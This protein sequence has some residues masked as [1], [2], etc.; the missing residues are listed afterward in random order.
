MSFI[1]D[2][3]RLGVA[4]TL[5]AVEVLIALFVRDGL[6]RPYGGD[7]LVV[8]L[9]HFTW[10]GVFRTAPR[11]VAM[12]CFAFACSVEAAQALGLAQHLGVAQHWAGRLILGTTFQWGDLLAYALGAVA[13]VVLDRALPARR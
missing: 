4:V 7:V 12:G 6:V 2:L 1:I 5:L 11:V 9:M 8:I 3:P 10:R 13:A